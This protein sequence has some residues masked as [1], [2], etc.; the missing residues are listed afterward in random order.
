MF[1]RRDAE[2]RESDKRCYSKY[3]PRSL[4]LR[5]AC[6]PELFR[7]Q[8]DDHQKACVTAENQISAVQSVTEHGALVDKDVFDGRGRVVG[9]SRPAVRRR[10]WKQRPP[11]HKSLKEKKRVEEAY[12]AEDHDTG[13]PPKVC[14]HFVSNGRVQKQRPQHADHDVSHQNAVRSLRILKRDFRNE[15][16]ADIEKRRTFFVKIVSEIVHRGCHNPAEEKSDKVTGHMEQRWLHLS[17]K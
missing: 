13:D 17:S 6:L 12:L 2:C 10:T 16:K 9:R 8:H 1:S 7:Q 5:S 14:P 4:H 15:E 11:P 3:P